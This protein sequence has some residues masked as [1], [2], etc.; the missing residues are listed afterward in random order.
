LGAALH[1]H[2]YSAAAAA[3]AAAAAVTA[4]TSHAA[5]SQTLLSHWPHS[6]GL[7]RRGFDLAHGRTE[8]GA[9]RSATNEAQSCVQH[10]QAAYIRRSSWLWS[11]CMIRAAHQC[12]CQPCQDLTH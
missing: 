9:Q 12:T 1:Y 3:A 2:H 4:A 7:L 10:M 5:S 11:C 6:T 8:P